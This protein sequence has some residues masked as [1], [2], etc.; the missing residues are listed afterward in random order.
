VGSRARH[1][2]L[3]HNKVGFFTLLVQMRRFQQPAHVH[4]R[5]RTRAARLVAEIA[6]VLARPQKKRASA[7]I[8]ERHDVVVHILNQITYQLLGVGFVDFGLGI[9]RRGF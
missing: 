4:I 1:K 5:V 3:R 9:R 8:E 2:V 7:R 6:N